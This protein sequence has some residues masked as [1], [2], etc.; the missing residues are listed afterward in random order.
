MSL[1]PT[2]AALGAALL[3]CACAMAPHLWPSTVVSVDRMRTLAPL[4][5][6]VEY[7]RRDGPQAGTVVLRLHV[8]ETGQ[9]L[10]W[11]VLESSGH[12]NLDEAARDAAREARFAPH[13]IDG[14]ATPV[15][16]V[17]PMHF[18]VPAARNRQAAP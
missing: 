15:T 1:H 16:V 9:V 7:R 3:A 17:A 18:G 12:A 4:H 5:T 13:R 2:A 6:R 11:A 10:R 14:M 8:D